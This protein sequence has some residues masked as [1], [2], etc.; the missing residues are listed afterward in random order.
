MNCIQILYLFKVEQDSKK[1][2]QEPLLP[3]TFAIYKIAI[4]YH[5]NRNSSISV[6]FPFGYSL[7]KKRQKPKL[8]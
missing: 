5:T 3:I 1:I 7:T 4:L 6:C 8:E 2:N